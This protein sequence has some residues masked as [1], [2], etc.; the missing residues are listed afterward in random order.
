MIIDRRAL[1]AEFL[2]HILRKKFWIPI[3]VLRQLAG[4]LAWVH[5]RETKNDAVNSSL[6][7]FKT[8]LLVHAHWAIC[9]DMIVIGSICPE[10]QDIVYCFMRNGLI[11]LSDL[12]QFNFRWLCFIS[13]NPCEIFALLSD[14]KFVFGAI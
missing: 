11:K 7:N 13:G 8:N 9:E 4:E 5:S 6:D 10:R 12:T 2:V 3:R 14:P 1:L